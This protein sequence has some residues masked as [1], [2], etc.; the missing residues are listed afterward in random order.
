MKVDMTYAIR[1]LPHPFD[2]SR[3][4]QGE[5]AICLVREIRDRGHIISQDAVA[6]FA[7]DSEAATFIRYLVS[8]GIDDFVVEPGLEA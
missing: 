6:L 7:F 3:R 4:K 8:Q 1:K 2:P 5:H